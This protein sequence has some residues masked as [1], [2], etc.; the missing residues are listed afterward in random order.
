MRSIES[1]SQLARSLLLEPLALRLRKGRPIGNRTCL[2]PAAK[3]PTCQL[4]HLAN[5]L[6]DEDDWSGRLSLGKQ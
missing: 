2:V 1:D 5:Y 6:D 3:K 4:A